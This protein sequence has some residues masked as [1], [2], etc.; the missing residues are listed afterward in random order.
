MG[1][2]Y[3]QYWQLRQN[4]PHSCPSNTDC[5]LGHVFW[6]KTFLEPLLLRVIALLYMGSIP[7][8]SPIVA[9]MLPKL[10]ALLERRKGRHWRK[11]GNF[12]NTLIA[13]S[14][15]MNSRHMDIETDSEIYLWQRAAGVTGVPPNWALHAAQEPARK[16]Q[17]INFMS[18]PSSEV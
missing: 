15:S 7:L 16:L 18:K 17:F 12:I 4:T 3:Q 5:G 13:I 14:M 8:M 11:E 1:P 10:C 2:Y 6:P 9:Q